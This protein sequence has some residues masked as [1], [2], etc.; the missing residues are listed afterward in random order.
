MSKEDRDRVRR[1]AEQRAAQ[2]R[3]Q[4]ERDRKM[5]DAFDKEAKEL[6]GYGPKESRH[7]RKREEANNKKE[8]DKKYEKKKKGCLTV[9]VLLMSV[10]VGV[11]YG[12]IE[13]LS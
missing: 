4:R 10:P 9:L 7:A 12:V 2:E 11:I 1:L 3:A 8:V 5:D 13:L 6:F